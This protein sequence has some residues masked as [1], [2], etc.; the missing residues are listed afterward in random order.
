MSVKFELKKDAFMKKGVVGYSY[1]SYFFCAFV[2]MLREDGK[3]FIMLLSIWLLTS[4]PSYLV[5]YFLKNFSFNPD[6]LFT[7]IL[8]P[9]LYIKYKYILICHALFSGILSIISIAVWIY[10]GSW[11]NKNYTKRLLDKG[12]SP[13]ENDNYALALLKEYGCLEYTEDEKEDKEKMR[14]YKN[15]TDTVKKDEKSKYYI[16]MTY[17]IIIFVIT[18]IVN[19]TEI[20]KVGD[21]TYLEAIQAA[22]R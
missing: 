4:A 15:I 22:G 18:I 11:Y 5:N 6:S 13:S 2:P 9:L 3:G 14:L 1:T 12:Y 16:F 8:I 21:I 10:V 7:K 20:I 19:Y 17:F